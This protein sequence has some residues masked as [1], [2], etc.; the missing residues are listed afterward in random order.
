MRADGKRPSV[1]CLVACYMAMFGEYAKILQN[2]GTPMAEWLSKG[3][4]WKHLWKES[5]VSFENDRASSSAAPADMGVNIPKDL[6]QQMKTNEN[7]MRST[8]ADMAKLHYKDNDSSGYTGEN[9]T[10]R[11]KNRR[12]FRGGGRGASSSGGGG[13][14]GGGKDKGGKDKS[15]GRGGKSANA[16]RQVSG[17]RKAWNRR[18]GGGKGGSK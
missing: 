4:N 7:V 18:S 16:K 3:V 6:I 8:R 10:W 11:A 15:T 1:Q 14:K 2:H 13:G 17:G 9:A 12:A 5:I